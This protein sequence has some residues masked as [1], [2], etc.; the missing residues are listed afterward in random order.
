MSERKWIAPAMPAMHNADPL[1]ECPE[2]SGLSSSPLPGVMGVEKGLR[3]L[4]TTA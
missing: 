3:T 4:Q 2:Q 1:G